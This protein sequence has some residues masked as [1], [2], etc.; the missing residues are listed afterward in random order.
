MSSDELSNVIAAVKE[1]GYCFCKIISPN[2][3]G[4]T[5]AHQAGLYIPKNSSKFMFESPG[6]KG[7]NKERFVELVWSN[8]LTVNACFK[9]YGTGT[10]NEYRMTRLGVTFKVGELIILIKTTDNAYLGFRL[11][12]EIL[13][14]LFLKELD[15]TKDDTNS[16]INYDFNLRNTV[17]EP[18][19]IAKEYVKPVMSDDDLPKSDSSELINV[20]FRPKAHILT[21]L[22]EELIKDP[23][24]AI[25]EL[26]KNGYDADANRVDVYFSNITD[27]N[28]AT[29][30]VK[31]SGIGMT[32]DVLENVWLEP[33]TAFRKPLDINGKRQ[34]IRTPIYSRVPMG[35]KGVGRFAVHKLGKNIKLISRPCKINFDSEG[36]F[37]NKELLEYEINL[38]I[39]WN[40]FTQSKY[41]SDV[42]IIYSKNTDLKSFYFNENSGTYIKISNLKQIWNRG[43]ARQLKRHSLSMVSPKN[44]LQK[45]V[46]D[47]NFNNNWL[48]KF[49]DINE[50]LSQAPYKLTAILDQH[51]NLT[52]E[53]EFGL[54][55]NSG[56]GV[57][58][59][60]DDKSYDR[61]IIGSLRPLFRS[62]YNEKGYENEEL[63]KLLDEKA[64]LPLQFGAVM[65]DLYSYDLDPPSLKDVT[66]TP[67][68]LKKALKEQYGIKV[69][70]DDLRVYDYGEPGND[71]LALDIKR[72]NNKEWFSN[73]QNIGYV[74]LDSE[75]S[76]SLI[77]KTNRE[78]FINNE[79]FDYF[80]IVLEY[81]LIQ[82]RIERQKDRLKWL[83]YNKKDTGTNFKSRVANFVS[84]IN[85]AEI[86][87]E[88]KK[89]KLLEEAE[90]IENEY[91]KAQETLLIPAGVGMTA[92]VALHE[93]EKLVPR[94]EETVGIIPI[95]T[96]RIQDQVEEL[97]EYVSGILSVL[98]Q[99]GTKPVFVKEAIEQSI[100]NYQLK[101]R[102]RK[103]TINIEI[104]DHIETIKCD[105]RYLVTMLMNLIDNSIYW[106]DSIYKEDKRILIKAFKF[107]NVTRIVVADNGPGFND[108]IEEIV[109]PFFSRK[110]GG[111]GIG[112]YLIDTIMMKYGK[113]NIFTNEQEFALEIDNFYDGAIVELVFNKNQD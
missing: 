97:D 1:V 27:I 47:L 5:G 85:E 16:I 80:K 112:M 76:G 100:V 4:I 52:F 63:E 9:Y 71:W 77:E 32:D 90:K 79:S 34:I 93:I 64:H 109:T 31:D 10:R 98:K 14:D 24:M 106:L 26:V 113:L 104:D 46:I 75:T 51:Y 7:Q 78:G 50:L 42:K 41:L 40:S 105:K 54:A 44:D 21:L 62:Y 83:K 72:V 33:G 12:D 95:D 61:N 92:S 91:E 99:A 111:I 101:L 28:A 15:I 23:V 82:F 70:K 17:G 69:F 58:N 45:F 39:D 86:D 19:T 68:I 6:I 57:R 18:E 87:N 53:Y 103:I 74:Y 59:I 73:N 25:Y 60:K 11:S 81:I 108:S 66:Y 37:V 67:D 2:D 88:D 89:Q 43:M 38:E 13:I 94:M 29:I 107:E 110:E 56:I 84:L 96:T 20:N 55:N 35:E 49:P 36:N 3:A 65:I 102:L 30:I 8:G 48:D 22:G